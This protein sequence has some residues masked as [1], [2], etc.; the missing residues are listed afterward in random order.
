MC[1]YFAENNLLTKKGTAYVIFQGDFIYIWGNIDLFETDRLIFYV[2]MVY[3]IE[4]GCL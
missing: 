2:H 3:V 4:S 1:Y